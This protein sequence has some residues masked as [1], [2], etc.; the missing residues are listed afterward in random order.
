MECLLNW[1][2]R[3]FGR[4]RWYRRLC[5]GHWECW[6]LFGLDATVWFSMDRCSADADRL[7]SPLCNGVPLCEDYEEW[8]PVD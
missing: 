8:M 5:G 2:D 3:A 4:F 7:P 1:V 6:Y